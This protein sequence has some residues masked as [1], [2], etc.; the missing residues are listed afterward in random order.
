MTGT[1]FHIPTLRTERLV[2]RAAAL[3]DAPAFTAFFAS[4]R[5]HMVGGP[6]DPREAARSMAAM[7]GQWALHGFGMWLVADR[8][9]DAALGWT[10]IIYQPGWDEPELGWTLFGQ[11]EGHGIAFEA[12]TAARAYAAH[13]LGIGSPISYIRADNTRSIALAERLGAHLEREGEVLG[14]PCLVYRHPVNGGA[15]GPEGDA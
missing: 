9:S 4:E 15:T 6:R 10:G 13:R 5:S 14:T 8:R 11:A 12:A 1:D 2:L 7:I 3:K